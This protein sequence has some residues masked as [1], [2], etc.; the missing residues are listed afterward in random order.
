MVAVRVQAALGT[1]QL[2]ARAVCSAYAVSI[3]GR[4][5]QQLLL[6]LLPRGTVGNMMHIYY[7]LEALTT[8]TLLSLAQCS[9]ACM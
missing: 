6:L 7:Y 1:A 3:V 5:P 9:C 4:V 8:L 2:N